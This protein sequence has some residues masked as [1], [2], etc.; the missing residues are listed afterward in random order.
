MK[1]TVAGGSGFIGTRLV[2]HVAS[3]GDDVEVVSRTPSKVTG[4]PAGARA[5][6]W[7]GLD[8]SGRDAV[9]NLA[10]KSLFDERWNDRVKD[11]IVRSRVDTTRAVVD[12]IGRA[13]PR[14]RVLVNGSAVGW[15]GPRGD[16]ELDET[17]P[18]GEDFLS[19]T[20]VAWEA[21]AMRAREH[22]VR[23]VTLRTGVAL[24][25]EDGA[26]PRMALPF[27][28]FVGGRVGS[29]AQWMPWIHVDDLV[30]LIVFCVETPSV[31]GP[32]NAA[33]PNPLRNVEFAKA[34]G[35]ALG[36]PSW[37]PAPAFALRLA[38]GE[39]ATLVVEGQRAVPR[40][41]LA[42]GFPFRFPTA[43]GALADLARA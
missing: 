23:V 16:D 2:A 10:G 4:L 3:R 9:V 33:A 21:E 30:R 5:V 1:W 24:G 32:V 38:L 29:G 12:A 26:L 13:S 35:R 19:R 14:P 22:G 8:V 31:E 34:L 28:L 7:E 40:K 25:R 18:P 20:C 42:Q 6:A 39:V 36:R 43:E 37:L 17:A 41:A 15:Y 11:E 27:K